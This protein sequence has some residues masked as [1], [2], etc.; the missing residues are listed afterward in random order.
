[1]SEILLSQAKVTVVYHAKAARSGAVGLSAYVTLCHKTQTA[2]K[3][4]WST[5]VGYVC[6]LRVKEL[7]NWD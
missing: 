7:R 2:A 4:S 5:C 6:Y 3:L 1:M